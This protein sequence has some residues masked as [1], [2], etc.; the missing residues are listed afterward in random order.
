MLQVQAGS[1]LFLV[2]E[3]FRNGTMN[4]PDRT[5][6]QSQPVSATKRRASSTLVKPFPEANNSS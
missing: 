1:N 6:S 3:A 4:I 5:E 2:F